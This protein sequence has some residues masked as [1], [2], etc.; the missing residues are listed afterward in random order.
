M[1][2]D[3][4]PNRSCCFCLY[5]GFE[6]LTLKKEVLRGYIP[7]ENNER[8]FQGEVF[9]R[10]LKYVQTHPRKSRLKELKG[11]LNVIVEDVTDLEVAKN[12][13]GEMK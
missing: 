11:K 12:V 13:L 7:T 6:K 5:I 10:I 2:E 4:S 3:S 8:Y 9:G 1:K